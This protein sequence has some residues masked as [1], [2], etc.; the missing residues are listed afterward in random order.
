MK[1][2]LSLIMIFCILL[3]A[4]MLFAEEEMQ[5]APS[6]I[7]AAEAGNAVSGPLPKIDTGDT[8]WMIVATALVMLMT[9][10]G[11]ALFYGGLAKRKDM[12][13]TMAM[14]FVTF[15]IVSVLWV[16]YGYTFSFSGDI[17]GVIGN[18][19]KLFLSG[20]GVHSVVDAAKT[21]P[22]YIFI[23]YQLTFAAITV[24]LASGAYIERMKFSA[25]ILFS[26]LWLTLA[27]LPV[28]HWMWGGG[29]LAKLGALDFA[30][31]TVVHINA[32]IAA[33]V[34]ALVLGKRRQAALMPNNLTLVVTGAGLLWF[35]WFGFNAGSALAA[36]GLAAA[37][38]INTNTATAIAAVSWMAAE[39]V[40][41]K[42]PTVLGLA[43][44][45]V[46]GLVAITPAAGFVNVSG[47][48]FI[49][50]AAGIV[51]FFSVAVMKP[52]FGYDD[53]LDAFGIHGVAGTLG[54][55]LTG[56]FA[57]P[58]INEAGK[59]LLYGN[60]SQLLRQFIAVG[61]TFAYTGIVTFIVFMIV[62]ALIGLRVDED[63]EM[64][65]L[66][67]S[68]H[69]ERAYNLQLFPGGAAVHGHGETL[70]NYQI[71]GDEKSAYSEL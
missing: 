65:G 18:G 36:N 13:N 28:A 5:S 25:W 43:S 10:P 34:G 46:A 58:S 69:G 44:G 60:P 11:L 16:L 52:K 56:V 19:A 70:G 21:I 59:G 7:N 1:I 8:A 31:G 22:E 49:G 40:H 64:E 61:V 30:G 38:F 27:Y 66:D 51:A 62:K 6:Q 45:A 24:A 39:W 9:L 17:G 63:A 35:G 50:A 68:E 15:C 71:L 14:S 20:V 42:K 12:L 41:S 33:L 54:A 29:F 67:E 47:A 2:V 23:V 32:G 37:A 55:M 57:D 3:P 48:L 53:T 4:G 26:I